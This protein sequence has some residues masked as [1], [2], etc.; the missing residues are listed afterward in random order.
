[1]IRY[2]YREIAKSINDA[3]FVLLRFDSRG[4]GSGLECDKA[5]KHK[6][7]PWEYISGNSH[8]YDREAARTSTF[9]NK[10]DDFISIVEMLS[11]DSRFDIS[12][13]LIVAHSEGGYH[14]ANLIQQCRIN[15]KGI[16]FLNTPMESTKDILYWQEVDQYVDWMRRLIKEHHGYVKNED[17]T[18]RL[19]LD[20]PTSTKMILSQGN[21]WSR[22]ELTEFR[23]MLDVNYKDFVQKVL[24][25]PKENQ[26]IGSMGGIINNLELGSISY[27]QYMMTNQTRPID[28]LANFKGKLSF[29][30]GRLDQNVPYQ[31]QV[32]LIN[33]NSEIN[34]KSK[35]IILDVDHN[36]A[37]PDGHVDQ[38]SF[39]TIVQEVQ[40]MTAPL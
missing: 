39:R 17:I 20:K 13:L 26:T 1:M 37:S 5:F 9:L 34:K 33:K 6:V 32:D 10:E 31:K 30:Y 19:K 27:I 22:E 14:T 4:V 29:I 16:I 8:C 28:Q 40:L 18:N 12:R 15:P 3:G 23:K 24:D 25:S 7:N 2:W 11:K 36:F 38:K 21:G 35:V